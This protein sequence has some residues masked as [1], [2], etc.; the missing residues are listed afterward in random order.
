MA[1]VLSAW[2]ALIA[3]PN[4]SPLNVSFVPA[5]SC[6]CLEPKG[7]S[8][9]ATTDEVSPAVCSGCGSVDHRFRFVIEECSGS[10]TL[11]FPKITSHHL[12]VT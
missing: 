11:S 1:G 2:V 9:V 5:V 10:D 7:T 6:P 12:K 3:H 8:A 4:A